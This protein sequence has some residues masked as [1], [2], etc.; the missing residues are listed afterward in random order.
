MSAVTIT[1]SGRVLASSV[2]PEVRASRTR[3]IDLLILLAGTFFYTTAPTFVNLML[4]GRVVGEE[5]SSGA[6]TQTG[7]GTALMT[8]RIPVILLIIAVLLLRNL[9]RPKGN[10]APLAIFGLYLGTVQ[11]ASVLAEVSVA[12][13]ARW[14]ILPLIALTVWLI[15]P[16]VDDLQVLGWATLAVAVFS[17]GFAIVDP[18]RAF[19]MLNQFLRETN[20]A[21]IGDQQ[22]AGP[23][24]QMNLLGMSMAVGF[25]FLFLIKNKIIRFGGAGVV[26]YTLLWSASR[27]SALALLITIGATLFALLF[28]K[29]ATRRM[30]LGWAAV[31]LAAVVVI[32]PLIT[33][34]P[35]A[36]TNRGDIW[37]NAIAR[38]GESPIFG[39]GTR[40]FSVGTPIA[41]AIGYPSYHGHNTFISAFTMGGTV[42]I[43][44]VAVIFIMLWR[45]ANKLGP[46]SLVP[47]VFTVLI[48]GLG[49]TEV[50]LRM[51]DFDGVAWI[52]WPAFIFVFFAVANSAR[53]PLAPSASQEAAVESPA[54]RESVAA[55]EAP[56]EAA[57]AAPAHREAVAASEALRE[58]VAASPTPRE[59]VIAAPVPA[60]AAAPA[61]EAP[62]RRD[63]ARLRAGA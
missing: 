14:W 58:A 33:T 27:T 50:P 47:L 51:D 12:T 39:F 8:L 31:G 59:P 37:I 36:Y 10:I 52:A 32:L 54:P 24:A 19:M 11:F 40:A 17:I 43:I 16:R 30:F 55:S 53:E 25:P 23:F 13:Q 4:G 20:K 26:F 18:A 21:I 41:R 63:R 62:L 6:V 44:M 56:R 42:L 45:N 60:A 48:I 2:D 1:P 35:T 28:R 3:K 15:S 61:A 57:V 5:N 9:R 46:V 49:M 29:N 38:W 34:D 22:L 7:A